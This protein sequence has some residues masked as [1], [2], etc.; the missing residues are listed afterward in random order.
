MK[1]DVNI[2]EEAEECLARETKILKRLKNE[3]TKLLNEMEELSK[4]RKAIK[5]Y[6]PKFPFPPMPVFFDKKG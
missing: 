1:N 6:S 4:N 3:C 5:T 2:S